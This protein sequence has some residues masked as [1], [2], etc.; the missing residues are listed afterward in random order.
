VL[1]GEATVTGRRGAVL[2]QGTMLI[3]YGKKRASNCPPITDPIRAGYARSDRR[4]ANC[5]NHQLRASSDAAAPVG[6]GSAREGNG[7]DA[8]MAAIDR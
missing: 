8:S 5:V 3:G 2:K 6:A 4:S 7:A 1:S